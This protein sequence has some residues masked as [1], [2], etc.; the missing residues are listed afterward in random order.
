MPI[1]DKF[2]RDLQKLIEKANPQS[3]EELQDFL[4][5]LMGKHSSTQIYRS[6]FCKFNNAPNKNT[7]VPTL[8]KTRFFQTIS[9]QAN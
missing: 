1:P 8:K 3:M 6:L 9:C 7:N 2:H 4:N 5:S